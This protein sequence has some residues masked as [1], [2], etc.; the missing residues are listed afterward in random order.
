MV[1]VVGVGMMS[2][3]MP[4]HD[5]YVDVYYVPQLNDRPWIGD[6]PTNDDGKCMRLMPTLVDQ[7]WGVRVVVVSWDGEEEQE[8]GGRQTHY[9]QDDHDLLGIILD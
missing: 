7:D 6:Y 9:S 8:H 1:V 2:I 4:R 5:R 3:T